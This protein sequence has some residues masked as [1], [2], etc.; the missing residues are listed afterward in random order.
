MRHC[1]ECFGGNATSSPQCTLSIAPTD[2]SWASQSALPEGIEVTKPGSSNISYS[3]HLLA[4]SL[5]C[6]GRGVLIFNPS[7]L[8]RRHLD[9]MK[10]GV[11]MIVY[12]VFSTVA[13]RNSTY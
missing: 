5:S 8:A 12:S 9:F 4:L 10:K 2:G 3:L 1:Q 11:E 7:V 13:V 6:P